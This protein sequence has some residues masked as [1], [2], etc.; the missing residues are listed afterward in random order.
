MTRKQII[1]AWIVGVIIWIVGGVVL[2]AIGYAKTD[3]EQYRAACNVV[4]PLTVSSTYNM[5]L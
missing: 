4:L 5:R 2:L 1:T 3:D